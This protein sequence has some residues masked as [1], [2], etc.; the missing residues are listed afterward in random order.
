MTNSDREFL[1]LIKK[2]RK[3][4]EDVQ[5]AIG[6]QVWKVE[7][8]TAWL[9]EWEKQQTQEKVQ[10]VEAQRKQNGKPTQPAATKG[11]PVTQRHADRTSNSSDVVEP[12]HNVIIEHDRDGFM[13]VHVENH[14][15]A[16]PLRNRQRLRQ[17][18]LALGATVSR[19][20]VPSNGIIPFKTKA[21]LIEAIEELSG[22]RISTGNLQN[23]V[24]HL[25]ALFIK[26]HINP[27]LIESGGGGYR[28]RLY[29]EG[30]IFE[31]VS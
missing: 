31:N 28:L 9:S 26:A 7:I 23:L 24:Q 18:L 25:R 21:E 8:V 6:K 22:K 27:N 17:L 2:T 14:E 11:V 15:L 3:D 4:L 1:Q 20:N 30:R 29:V 13:L 10:H 19:V 12:V 5:T 16:V